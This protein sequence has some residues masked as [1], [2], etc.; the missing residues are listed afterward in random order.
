MFCGIFR[1]AV[2]SPRQQSG[3]GHQPGANQHAARQ[4][5][6]PC[7]IIDQRGFGICLGQRFV[8]QRHVEHFSLWTAWRS[9]A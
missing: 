4:F 9:V 2:K 3:R 1:M 8:P 5:R 7:V 6:S